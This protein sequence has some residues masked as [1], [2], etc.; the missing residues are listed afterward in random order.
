MQWPAFPFFKTLSGS[1]S[2][3]SSICFLR[4]RSG[5]FASKGPKLPK[6]TPR[7]AVVG[8]LLDQ[9]RTLDGVG[10]PSHPNRPAK[11]TPVGV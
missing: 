8:G 3:L 6:V 4:R 2:T 7:R 9:R 1:T 11:I 5:R 10:L